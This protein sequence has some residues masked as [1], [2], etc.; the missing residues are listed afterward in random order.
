MW[1][2]RE[3]V[4]GVPNMLPQGSMVGCVLVNKQMM[5]SLQISN[6]LAHI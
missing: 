3:E 5:L 2:G 6:G 4:G 1:T